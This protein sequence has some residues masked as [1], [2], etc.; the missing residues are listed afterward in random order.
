MFE[1]CIAI[2]K[3]CLFLHQKSKQSKTKNQNNEKS[4]QSKS[5]NKQ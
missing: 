2:S 4:N 1:K 5:K 3:Y